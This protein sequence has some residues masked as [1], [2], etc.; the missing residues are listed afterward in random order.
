MTD[1]ATDGSK[2]VTVTASASGFTAGSAQITVSDI[3]LP[4]IIVAGITVPATADT[5]SFASIG[6]QIR[7]QG[8]TG[9][10]SNALSQ[11]I[12]LSPDPLVGDDVLIS[13]YVFNGALPINTQFG[14][15]FPACRVRIGAKETRHVE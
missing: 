3:N 6:Y 2:I 9:A 5:E 11:R 7:N 4:D 1:G 13:Q 14:Q 10:S 15:S 8:L 12:Y